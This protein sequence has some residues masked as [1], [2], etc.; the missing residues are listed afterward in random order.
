VRRDRFL[1]ILIVPNNA[2]GSLNSVEISS[3]C[4]LY[5]AMKTGMCKICSAE[6]LRLGSTCK[7]FEIIPD[8]SDEN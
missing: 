3:L 6:G 2:V 8:K 5:F 4:S 7:R 1:G